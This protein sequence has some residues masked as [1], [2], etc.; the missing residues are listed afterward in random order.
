MGRTMITSLSIINGIGA[1]ALVSISYGVVQRMHL[2]RWVRHSIL[3][4]IFGVG[5]SYAMMV[6]VVLESGATLE[7]QNLLIAYAA[8][9][10]GPIGAAVSILIAGSARM[11][12]ETLVSVTDVTALVSAAVIG[13]V[14]NTPTLRPKELRLRHCAFMGLQ[15]SLPLVVFL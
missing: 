11:M 3:G 15:I 13:L 4:L 9:F 2:H 8:F 7:T 5:A 12:L 1:L 6:P 10:T 14:W